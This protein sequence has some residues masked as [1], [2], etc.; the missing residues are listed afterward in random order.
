MNLNVIKY[1]KIIIEYIF[2]YKLQKY[3][4]KLIKLENQLLENEINILQNFYKLY[5]MKF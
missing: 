4:I 3:F 2:K 5:K 1:N